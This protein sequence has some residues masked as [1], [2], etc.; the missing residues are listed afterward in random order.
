MKTNKKLTTLIFYKII[1]N[2]N[3]ILINIIEN[4]KSINNYVKTFQS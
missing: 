3:I 2:C 1:Y 4:K